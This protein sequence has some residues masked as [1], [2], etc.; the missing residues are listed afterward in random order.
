MKRSALCLLLAL[1]LAGC[2]PAAPAP[3]SASI[4]PPAD[5]SSA[6]E[7]PALPQSQTADVPPGDYA[8]W[9]EGYAGFLAE[10]RTAEYQYQLGEAA[11]PEDDLPS[12]SYSLYDVDK[13]GVPE[14]FLKRGTCE[15]DYYTLVYT[16]R[17]GQMVTLGSFRS[18]HSSLYTVPGENG[19]IYREGHMGYGSIERFSLED[20]GVIGPWETLLTETEED[21]RQKG[22]TDPAEL[23]PG[24]QLIPSHYTCTQFRPADSPALV[25]PVCDYQGRELS[26]PMEE[27]QVRAVIER[28]LHENAPLFGV[29]GD[30]FHGDTGL[31]TLE[32]YLRPGAAYPYG[33]QPLEVQ[34]TAWADVNGD[35]QTDC[36]LWLEQKR[37]KWTD[38]FCAVLSAEGEEVFAYFFDFFESPQD[39]TV[40]P[41][42]AVTFQSFENYWEQVSFYRNQCYTIPAPRPAGDGLAWDPF[43]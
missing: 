41:D 3:S 8:P 22:Y 9:Q 4:S 14:L 20:G 42:G 24:S 37:E 2:A 36:L 39:V 43:P 13:D 38:H 28:V 29:S 6:P 12:D 25:L 32:E 26:V 10:V 18:G 17:S 31:T 33:D 27:P 19:I 5:H 21:T 35:G 30:G 40:E 1:C 15:A 16:F 23:V 11:C 7:E 34:K